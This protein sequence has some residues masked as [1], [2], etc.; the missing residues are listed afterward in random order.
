[1]YSVKVSRVHPDIINVSIPTYYY[2]YSTY[3]SITTVSFMPGLTCI[4]AGAV[5]GPGM[6]LVSTGT[7]QPMPISTVTYDYLTSY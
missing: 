7:D 1:M 2:T 5:R 6:M 3:T 4:Y